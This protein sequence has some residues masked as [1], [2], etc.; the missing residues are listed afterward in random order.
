MGRKLL[1]GVKMYFY[2]LEAIGYEE[3]WKTIYCS[4]KSYSEEEFNAKIEEFK[5]EGY[6]IFL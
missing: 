2:K 6:R 5:R 3:H 1:K 4:S